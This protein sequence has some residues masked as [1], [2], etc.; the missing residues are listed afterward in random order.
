MMPARHMV[1]V[2]LTISD[3]LYQCVCV[4]ILLPTCV[5]VC[6]DIWKIVSNCCTFCREMQDVFLASA[7]LQREPSCAE[8]AELLSTLASAFSL[9]GDVLY[10]VL[11]IYE[12]I[13]SYVSNDFDPSE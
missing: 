7:R 12:K 11:S 2:N 9:T 3:Y 1:I 13:G 6:V 5:C 4:K 8:F 10:D